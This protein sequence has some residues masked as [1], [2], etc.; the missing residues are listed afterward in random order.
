MDEFFHS[1]T[2]EM[3]GTLWPLR[4]DATLDLPGG[5]VAPRRLFLSMS[6][7][8]PDPDAWISGIGTFSGRTVVEI[9]TPQGISAVGVQ[10][11]D[12][13]NGD[14]LIFTTPAAASRRLSALATGADDPGPSGPVLGRATVIASSIGDIGAPSGSFLRVDRESLPLDPDCILTRESDVHGVTVAGSEDALLGVV[15]V[16]AGPGVA[17]S[18]IDGPAVSV[19]GVSDEEKRRLRCEEIG[20]AVP[21]ESNES[22]FAL[23]T[24]NGVSPDALGR[25]G[26][27][28]RPD[29]TTGTAL[30]V[31]LVSGGIQFYIVGRT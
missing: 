2:A 25:I 18:D 21:A 13:F 14:V 5:R 26:M 10:D 28:Q 22:K 6:I 15:W 7:V 9:S 29:G 30:R 17:F 12:L 24:I 8:L 4:A 20:V 23:Q 19:I 27:H 31:R 11:P 16:I 3:D 1:K